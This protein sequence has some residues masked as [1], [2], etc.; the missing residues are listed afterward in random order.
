MR[1]MIMS[2]K[3]ENPEQLKNLKENQKV[4]LKLKE[5]ATEL[6]VTE[7]SSSN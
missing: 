5:T 7:I 2:Y 3:V 6:T 4:K 1:A